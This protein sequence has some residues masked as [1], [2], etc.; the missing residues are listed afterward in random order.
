MSDDDIQRLERRLLEVTQILDEVVRDIARLKGEQQNVPS[1]QRPLSDPAAAVDE[2]NMASANENSVDQD[3]GMSPIEQEP[4]PE[5]SPSQEPHDPSV[6]KVA[7]QGPDADPWTEPEPAPGPQSQ[8][9]AEPEPEPAEPGFI[10]TFFEEVVLR[11]G[12][13]LMARLFGPIAA[14]IETATGLYRHYQEQ[15]KAPVFLMTA[16]GIVAL[17]SGFGYGL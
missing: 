8:R 14:A 9:E 15:G 2:Q 12:M 1:A 16:V 3:R 6:V 5:K 7:A 10:R 4:I 11:S 17:V 13:L